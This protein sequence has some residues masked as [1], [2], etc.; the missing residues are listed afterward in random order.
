MTKSQR[1]NFLLWTLRV[2]PIPQI[3]VRS[4]V[5]QNTVPY[6]NWLLE[7]M[8]KTGFL[9]EELLLYYCAQDNG[10]ECPHTDD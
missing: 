8:F 5:A 1:I 2:H 10:G 9:P 3:K 6:H 4:S 7:Q